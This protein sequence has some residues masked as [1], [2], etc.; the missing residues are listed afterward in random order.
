ME[1]GTELRGVKGWLLFLVLVLI[2]IGP[3]LGAL[4]VHSELEAVL[5]GQQALEGTEEWFDI[6]GA[7]W[8]AWGLGAILSVI[9]GLLL[10][11]A[12]KPWAVTAVITLLWLM[13][14]ILSIFI[15]WDSGLEFD[16]SVSV[17]IVKTTA[18]AS[19]WTLYLMISKG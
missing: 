1:R 4:G 3:L 18:S 5:A 15:V 17:A 6:Q 9:A 13:G 11:I 12:R 2:L 7:A 10:L 14:P 19:L 8:V 16:G